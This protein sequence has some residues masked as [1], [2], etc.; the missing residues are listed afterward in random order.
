[1]ATCKENEPGSGSIGRTIFRGYVG[2]MGLCFFAHFS[3]RLI[4]HIGWNP[5][6]FLALLVARKVYFHQASK[7]E[8]FFL[9]QKTTRLYTPWK[10]KVHHFFIK[11]AVKG[12]PHT[13]PKGLTVSSKKGVTSR[14]LP[15][16][17]TSREILL[18]PKRL[19]T[20][21]VKLRGGHQFEPGLLRISG[22]LGIHTQQ[23]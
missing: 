8:P 14:V 6:D 12:N 7:K 9:S 2:F 13:L 22:R 19:S 10:S 21:K 3:L 20:V 16:V 11:G 18:A 4:N 23:A 17:F 5:W 15:I 1:M